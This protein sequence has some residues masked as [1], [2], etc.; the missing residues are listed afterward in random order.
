ML[1]GARRRPA[2]DR[3]LQRADAYSQLESSTT[4]TVMCLNNNNTLLQMSNRQPS[5]S[6][7][8]ADEVKNRPCSNNQ[9]SR[10][11]TILLD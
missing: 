5:L 7:N 4:A 2:P 1:T 6:T 10:L 3:S 9:S 8:L 11:T